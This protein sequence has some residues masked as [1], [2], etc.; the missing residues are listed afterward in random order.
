[1]FVGGRTNS[2]GNA[3]RGPTIPIDAT[4]VVLLIGVRSLTGA[5]FRMGLRMKDP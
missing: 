1:M 5:V 3:G 2:Q 4:W